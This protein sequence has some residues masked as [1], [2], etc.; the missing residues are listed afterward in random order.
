MIRFHCSDL[1]WVIVRVCCDTSKMFID[2]VDVSESVS[3]HLTKATSLPR[4]T[5][6]SVATQQD[7]P[8]EARV[9]YY[10]YIYIAQFLRNLQVKEL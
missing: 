6:I 1:L 9:Y 3:V 4:F 5:E 2:F 10:Y 7:S 8:G